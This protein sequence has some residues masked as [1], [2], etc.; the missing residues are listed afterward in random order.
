MNV[1]E[2]IATALSSVLSNKMRSILTML[3]I[4]IGISSVIL[5]TSVGNGVSKMVNDEFEKIGVNGLEIYTNY[6]SNVAMELADKELIE[7]NDSIIAASSMSV[8]NGGEVK[9]KKTNE[10]ENIFIRGTDQNLRSV[11]NAELVSGNFI[12]EDDNKFNK[13]VIVIDEYTSK[14]IFGRTNTLGEKIEIRIDSINYPFTIIGIEKSVDSN[15]MLMEDNLFGYIPINTFIEVIGYREIF[16]MASTDENYDMVKV[17][18]EIKKILSIKYN[19]KPEEFVVND[20]AA[21]VSEINNI[22]GAIT[23]FI[24]FVAGIS[25]LVGGIGIMNI[26]LVT[27]TERTRE[28]GIRKSLGATKGNIQF[29]FLVESII[30]TGIGGL[31]GTG[32]G[33]IGGTVVGNMF[34]I[35]AIISVPIILLVVAISSGIG[36]IFGVYPAN[37]AANLDPIEA[38]RYE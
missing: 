32:L 24:S 16:I 5:I 28:I 2:S 26:M 13:K 25:L 18:D 21:M 27:V 20:I 15:E 14:K 1:K 36:I 37:K 3:G 6:D 19:T 22:F 10:K 8:Y 38:L 11:R 12:Q 31:I 9:I 29:Q 23:A 35:K 7:K 30:L 33:F 34:E 17:A 4:I